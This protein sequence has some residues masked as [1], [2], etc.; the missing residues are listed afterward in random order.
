VTGVPDRRRK[1]AEKARHTVTG[2]VPNTRSFLWATRAIHT[3]RHELRSEGSRTRVRPP[4][5]VGPR[6]TTGVRIAVVITR[7]TC[8]ER[9][10][11]LQ[12]WISGYS[13]TPPD[14]V[15]GIRKQDGTIE[16]HAWVDGSDPEF[17]GS[18]EELTRLR[19]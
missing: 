3:A 19:P 13:E 4:G 2:L 11:V 5:F 6:G 9:A 16:A 7:P 12:G 10:L 1:L 17:D 15:I 14:V 18:Y 8:L